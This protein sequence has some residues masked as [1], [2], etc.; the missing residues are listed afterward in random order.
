MLNVLP[1]IFLERL[2]KI[3]PA[4]LYSDVFS[5][6]IGDGVMSVRVNTLKAAHADVLGELAALKICFEQVRW[7]EDA[8]I[9]KNVST[10]ELNDLEL[11]KKNWLYRQSL[12]SML[13]VIILNPQPGER[14]LD[15]CA[16]PGSKTT[17]ISAKMKNQGEL[18]AV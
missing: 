9:I 17:Q 6:F 18:V 2:Q 10:K 14:V 1:P 3:I 12:S 8:L 15:F 11:I 7:S 4:Q 16:A 13:P 5:S